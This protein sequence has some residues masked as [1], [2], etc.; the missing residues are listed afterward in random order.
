MGFEREHIFQKCFLD[1]RIAVSC[2]PAEHFA[3]RDFINFAAQLFDVDF[4]IHAFETERVIVW[5]FR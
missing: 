3:A 2:L 1:L 4:A 5:K